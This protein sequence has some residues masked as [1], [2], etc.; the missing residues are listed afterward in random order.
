VAVDHRIPH[1]G[2][3]PTVQEGDMDQRS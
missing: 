1:A 3:E 2:G